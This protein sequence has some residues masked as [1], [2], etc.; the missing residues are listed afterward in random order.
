M[1]WQPLIIVAAVAG[2]FAFGWWQRSRIAGLV[3]KLKEEAQARAAAESRNE[4][5]DDVR[6]ADAATEDKIAQARDA[7]P[8]PGRFG[9]LFRW[10][11]KLPAPSDEEAT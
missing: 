1:A 8:N 7:G 9:V 11:E 6:D 4:F 2:I 3:A 10:G 5:T